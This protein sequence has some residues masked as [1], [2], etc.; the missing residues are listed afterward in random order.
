MA[1]KFETEEKVVGDKTV[2]WLEKVYKAGAVVERNGKTVLSPGLRQLIS[3]AHGFLAGDAKSK[4]YL[5]LEKAF[6]EAVEE[7][8]STAARS[9]KPRPLFP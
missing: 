4:T 1:K 7:A 6:D 5:E 8:S 2:E 9:T 3:A